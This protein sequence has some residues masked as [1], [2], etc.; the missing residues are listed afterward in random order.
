MA[1][2]EPTPKGVGSF[3]CLSCMIAARELCKREI[4]EAWPA[5]ISERKRTPTSVAKAGIM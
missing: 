1:S 5:R 2:S 3:L 4:G